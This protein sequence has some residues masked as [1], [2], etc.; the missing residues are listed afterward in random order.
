MLLRTPIASSI[1]SLNQDHRHS[2]QDCIENERVDSANEEEK[3]WQ[4]YIIV[5]L[6]SQQYHSFCIRALVQPKFQT[7]FFKLMRYKK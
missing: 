2:L 5:D 6:S 4:L 1:N 7:I 3:E